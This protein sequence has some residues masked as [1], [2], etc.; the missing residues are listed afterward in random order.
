MNDIRKEISLCSDTQEKKDLDMT[1]V[2]R[3]VLKDT[4]YIHTFL[5]RG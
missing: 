5:G 4:D 1:E 3:L 2:S